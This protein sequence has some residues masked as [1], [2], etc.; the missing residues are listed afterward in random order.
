M[1]RNRL[2]TAARYSRATGSDGC[3]AAAPWVSRRHRQA[4]MSPAPHVPGYDRR[5]DD[6]RV[7]EAIFRRLYTHKVPNLDSAQATTFTAS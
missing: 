6:V 1:N 5:S 7:A 3:L 4:R 2:L